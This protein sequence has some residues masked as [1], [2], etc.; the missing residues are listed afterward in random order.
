L[1][2]EKTKSILV[3]KNIENEGLNKKIY[4]LAG[5]CGETKNILRNQKILLTYF[6]K[7]KEYKKHRDFKK[8][9]IIKGVFYLKT[10][11]KF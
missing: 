3:E 8:K 11:I 6:T 7:L 4:G 10:F 1:Q 2:L 5:K 9:V